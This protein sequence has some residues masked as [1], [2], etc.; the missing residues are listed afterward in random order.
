M[1]E[2]PVDYQYPS[3]TPENLDT[4]ET[5]AT[6]ETPEGHDAD[7]PDTP[8]SHQTRVTMLTSVHSPFDTRIFYKEALTLVRAGY[9]VTLV[10]PHPHREEV[11]GV[12]LVPLAYSGSR[13]K[14]RTR[15]ASRSYPSP[16]GAGRLQRILLSPWRAFAQALRF[17]APVYHFHDP[18]LIPTGFLLRL[19]GKKV[20]YDVHE[21]VSAQ[22]TRKERL[23]APQLLASL[24]RTLE[25]TAC[26][27]F[28]LV[29]AEA[30]YTR[31]YPERTRKAVVQNFPQ[32]EIFPS[33]TQ[34]PEKYPTFTAGYLGGVSAI[35]GA[36][37]VLRALGILKERGIPANFVCI[38][39]ASEEYA[40]YLQQLAE[41]LEITDRVTFHGRM[42]APAAYRIL[43]QCHVGLAV[44]QPNPNYY[45][46]FP[47][48]MFEYM[49]LGLPVIVSD[50]PLWRGVVDK[51]AC[52]C[53]LD[54]TDPEA[55]ADTLQTLA[56]NP[57][58]A[59][60]LGE[61]GRRAVEREYRW[62]KEAEKLLQLY[63]HLLT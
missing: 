30:S 9:R 36:E 31:L 25:L 53:T 11:Q 35:R 26:R 18:E 37:R 61:N 63:Q 19:L 58:R 3:D 44:L 24:Y 29:L 28:A 4:Q 6:P 16:T 1:S 17:P 43:Q 40:A 46:S 48:K 45:H 15:T 34:A 13:S 22:I 8:S 52:G 56:H 57:S 60:R 23:P 21:N 32:L 33:P 2:N 5:Q 59:A 14:A 39:P 7:P 27:L 12:R 54:P 38:G 51:A 42:E 49:A 47:T 41:E 50:F 20:I 10:C 62:E 55:L